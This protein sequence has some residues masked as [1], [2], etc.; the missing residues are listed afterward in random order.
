MSSTPFNSFSE[1]LLV[2]VNCLLDGEYIGLSS[3]RKTI[4]SPVSRNIWAAQHAESANEPVE[5]LFCR[6]CGVMVDVLQNP[7]DEQT[8][9]QFLGLRTQLTAGENGG[10][11]NSQIETALKVYSTASK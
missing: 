11:F 1:A 3:P 7:G 2:S 6:A 8:N 9:E 5:A 10:F 4:P